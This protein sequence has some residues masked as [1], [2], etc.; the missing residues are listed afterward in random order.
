MSVSN[1]D[2]NKN[3]KEISVNTRRMAQWALAAGIASGRAAGF[4]V[5]P[6]Q[7][8]A[9]MMELV[10]QRLGDLQDVSEPSAP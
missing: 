5:L 6:I 1:Q 3:R 8:A 9:D 10:R 4:E 2:G 7:K